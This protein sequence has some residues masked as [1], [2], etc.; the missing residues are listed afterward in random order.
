MPLPFLTDAEITDMVTPLRQP[1]AIVRWFRA[2]GFL[3]K[4]KPNG[5]PLISRSHFEALMAAGNEKVAVQSDDPTVTP[6]VTAF[7]ARYKKGVAYENGT[8]SK[9]QS[10]RT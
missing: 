1:A 6:D 8:S 4:V 9:K 7:I 3:V 2:Q 5:M 10:A